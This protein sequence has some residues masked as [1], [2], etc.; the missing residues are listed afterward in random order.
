[1]NFLMARVYPSM[2]AHLRRVRAGADELFVTRHAAQAQQHDCMHSPSRAEIL[3]SAGMCAQVLMN[4]RPLGVQFKRNSAYVAQEDCFVPTMSANETLMFTA[5]LTLPKSVDAKE[6][7]QR[8]EEVLRIM[9]LWRSRETQAC[10]ASRRIW[11]L[12]SNLCLTAAPRSCC[13]AGRSN[14]RG[15]CVVLQ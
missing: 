4:G 5:T 11:F 14:G 13:A 12:W 3:N 1:M 7:A 10:T 9:G 2:P 6:R 8:I 15:A